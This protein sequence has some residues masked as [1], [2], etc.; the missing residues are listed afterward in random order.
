MFNPF[1]KSSREPLAV[2][3]AGV[4][5]G[6]RLLAVGMTDTA[7]IAAL[8]IKA[9]LTGRAVAVDADEARVRDGGAAIERE[10]A[11]VEV[12]RAPWETLPYDAASFDVAIMRDLLPSLPPDIRQR[13]LGEVLRVLRS[14][15]RLI[16]AETTR[17]GIGALVGRRAEDEAYASSGGATAAL[18]AS[19]FVGVRVLAEREGARFVEGARRG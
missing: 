18:E 4:K 8:A 16:V 10:G 7:L 3:M 19:G 11:L 2:T 5:L 12:A 13:C 17:S 14:G 6:D 1:R 15:G 9:G